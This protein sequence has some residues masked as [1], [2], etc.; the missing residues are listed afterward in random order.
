MPLVHFTPAK[1]PSAG[2]STRPVLERSTG[3][4]A[5]KWLLVFGA[6]KQFTKV[7]CS[8]SGICLSASARWDAISQILGTGY[9]LVDFDEAYARVLRHRPLSLRQNTLVPP[10]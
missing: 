9:W 8:Y 3:A 4:N 6:V 2:L 7:R 10:R 5:T 1:A